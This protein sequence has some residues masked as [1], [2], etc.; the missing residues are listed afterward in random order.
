MDPIVHY[1]KDDIVPE[2]PREADKV[3]RK[4]LGFELDGDHLYR[5]SFTKLD[6]RPLLRCLNAFEAAK[7]LEEIHEG[8]CGG[9][10]GEKALAQKVILLG[11]YL[12]TVIRGAQDY[13]RKCDKC[14]KYGNIRRKP[15]VELSTVTCSIPFAQWGMDLL[16]PFFPSSGQRKHILIMVDYF[17]K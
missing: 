4:S 8:T 5:R 3:R 9:H 6:G 2:D 14:Q 17:S 11:Y 12:L 13:V 15:T 10:I 16:G 7:V 1:L